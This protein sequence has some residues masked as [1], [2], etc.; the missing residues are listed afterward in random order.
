MVYPARALHAALPAFPAWPSEPWRLLQSSTLAFRVIQQAPELL[1]HPAG[2]LNR[3]G[4]SFL[5]SSSLVALIV[6]RQLHW[7]AG[8]LRR[9]AALSGG[10]PLAALLQ[11]LERASLLVLLQP[12]G[13]VIKQGAGQDDRA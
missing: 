12:N 9:L 6:R 2:S 4:P 8:R 13:P 7:A 11:H 3:R 1:A 5:S 10:L